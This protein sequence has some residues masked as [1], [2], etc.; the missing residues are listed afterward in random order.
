[1]VD[2]CIQW[3][4]DNITGEA[5]FAVLYDFEKRFK[6]NFNFAFQIFASVPS[7]SYHQK[8]GIRHSVFVVLTV[9]MVMRDS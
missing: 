9:G 6:M 2:G 8:I 3:V 7:G 4:R 5:W 1:V